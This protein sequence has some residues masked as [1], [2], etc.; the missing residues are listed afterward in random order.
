VP[1]ISVRS[2]LGGWG[3]TAGATKH[4]RPTE[5]GRL[6]WTTDNGQQGWVW[7]QRC[8]AGKVAGSRR[9]E[10]QMPRR[11]D[12]TPSG[13]RQQRKNGGVGW[14]GLRPSAGFVLQGLA[15][16]ELVEDGDQGLGAGLTKGGWVKISRG[17]I[18]RTG[19]GL[20]SRRI[21]IRRL[22]Y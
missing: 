7:D 12:P 21:D 16:A 18:S 19:V 2:S 22:S 1:F 5:R 14:F 4:T 9:A 17:R 3:R 8:V 6:G 10:R 13:L 20:E 11:D 15:A